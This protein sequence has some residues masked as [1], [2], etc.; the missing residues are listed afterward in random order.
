[1]TYADLTDIVSK[2]N[3]AW[4]YSD[5]PSY[6]VVFAVDSG[7]RYECTI[8]KTGHEAEGV[9]TELNAENLADFL[10][11][12]EPNANWAIGQRP[13]PFATGDFDYSGNRIPV[14]TITEWTSVEGDSY[15][16]L[17]FKIAASNLYM[18]GGELIMYSGFVPGDW[19]EMALADK[20]GA[21]SPAGTVL[22]SWVRG[23]NLHPGPQAGT[24][25]CHCN[26]PYAGH[27]PINVYVRVR[28]HR[29][30]SGNRVVGV[31]LE[32]HEAI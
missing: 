4:Q 19:A 16:D 8:Y 23:K 3:L 30:D 13:Y 15:A 2:K 31:N 9:D 24:A 28:I 32:L 27:P 5:D 6:Y 21:Y 25:L 22:K 11:N 12:I 1:M 18:N 7:I 14:T 10:A 17:W 26:T 29:A 20:D